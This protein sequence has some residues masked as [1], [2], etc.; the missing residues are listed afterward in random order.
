MYICENIIFLIS[1][2]ITYFNKHIVNKQFIP[3]ILAH[4]CKLPK[5]IKY[6]VQAEGR[7]RIYTE[8]TVHTKS[9]PFY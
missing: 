6:K 8:Y 9:T 3:Y 2:V 4:S 5:Y 7:W 1:W